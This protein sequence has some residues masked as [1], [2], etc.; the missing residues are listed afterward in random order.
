M[1]N[2]SKIVTCATTSEKSGTFFNKRKML[3][4]MRDLPIL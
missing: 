1:I 4:H 2:K 3:T